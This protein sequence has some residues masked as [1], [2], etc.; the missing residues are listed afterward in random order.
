MSLPPCFSTYA[1]LVIVV[2][3][4]FIL[5]GTFTLI[6][7]CFSLSHLRSSFGH[8]HCL[9]FPLSWKIQSMMHIFFCVVAAAVHSHRET[10]WPSREGSLK[11]QG[12]KEER[13]RERRFTNTRLLFSLLFVMFTLISNSCNCID[14]AVTNNVR[15]VWLV[16]LVGWLGQ[17]KKS[18]PT[19]RLKGQHRY[20]SCIAK[21]K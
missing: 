19:V 3:A 18:T 13:V 14:V 15:L 4:V 6:S 16:H 11:R 1:F 9:L 8:P 17:I 2:V 12:S 10:K 21:E 5:L 20:I 7:C